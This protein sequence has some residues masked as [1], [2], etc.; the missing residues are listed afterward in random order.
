MLQ[1]EMYEPRNWTPGVEALLA[2]SKIEV[3]S[4]EL[5]R[6]AASN[7]VI[8]G[9]QTKYDYGFQFG[10]QQSKSNDSQSHGSPYSLC[11]YV[12]DSGIGCTCDN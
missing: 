10:H 7:H 11:L 9:Y 4:I 1:L 5:I 2:R 6:D 8:G 12:N 3:S